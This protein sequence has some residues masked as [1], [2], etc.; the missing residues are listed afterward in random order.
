M[1]NKLI[2]I[3]I[4]SFFSVSIFSQV[5]NKKDLGTEVINVVK[6]YSPEVSDAYKIKPIPESD[7]SE[8]KKQ[9]L[10]YETFST[11]VVSTFKPTKIGAKAQAKKKAEKYLNN[12]FV[13]GYGNYKTPLVEF[14]MNNKKVKEQRYGVHVQ[15][16]SSEGGIDEVMFNDAFM[17]TSIE[18][19]YWKQFK[20][21]QLK[22]N[23]AY[24]YQSMNWYGAPEEW[25]NDELIKSLN[26]GQ[27]YQTIEGDV[28]LKNNSKKNDSFFK[29]ISATV[30]RMSD[31][32]DSYENR[33]KLNG[34][35]SIPIENQQIKFIADIDLMDNYFAQDYS[36][37]SEIKNQYIN[38]EITPSF[39]LIKE[40]ITLDLGV[41]MVYSADLE[42]DN[43]QF[44]I[45]PKVNASI[46]IVDD[47][48]I[49]YAGLEGELRQNS[50]QLLVD[51]MPY[52]SP[53]QNIIPTS[54]QY[55]A[56]VGLR[57]K[58]TSNL[59][60]NTSLSYRKENGF[61][62]YIMNDVRTMST[63]IMPYNTIIIDDARG[64]EVGNSF[65]VVQDTVNVLEFKAGLEYEASKDLL[66]G[67]NLEYNIY[68]S[69]NLEDV[70]NKPDLKIS[71]TAEYR[72]LEDF[73]VGTSMYYVSSRNYI[74][75]TGG[76]QP[77]AKRQA[78]QFE[79]TVT[80]T[81][82]SYFDFNINAKYDVSNKLS[83]FVRFNNVLS[84][85]YELYN[86]YHVQG[87]QAMAGISYKF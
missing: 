76:I 74:E 57:G 24:K 2:Y 55:N 5:E 51:E 42:G 66:I 56:F 36:R 13:L 73:T 79:N 4:F 64:W 16:L 17:N 83:T 43:S 60:Y 38:I 30:Y 72:F 65:S 39:E 82:S 27:Y 80:K 19:F 81:L 31:R 84:Q 46:N 18:G 59:A 25:I 50:L 45:Y 10:E 75:Y 22:T 68:S 6:A 58:L 29:S 85:N 12:Y 23:L 8:N 28:S 49:A 47:L 71:A 63:G 35:F 15:H 14:Y 11:D 48:M 7:S 52:L 21:Y 34:M 3:I 86:K 32:Y 41:N 78:T 20:K 69:Q 87:F 33:I 53:T 62:Q 40:N 70:Y 77:Y 26:V 67:A 1:I 54:V 37:T 61:V 9:D 44:K